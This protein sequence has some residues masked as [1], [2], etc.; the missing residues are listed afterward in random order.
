MMMPVLEDE[1]DYFWWCA[2]CG[3]VADTCSVRDEWLCYDC[4]EE[5]ME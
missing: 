2:I 5:Y 3:E 4:A 1:Y